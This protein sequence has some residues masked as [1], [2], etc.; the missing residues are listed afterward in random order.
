MQNIVL[1]RSRNRRKPT[2]EK[3]NAS[4]ARMTNKDVT[5]TNTYPFRRPNGKGLPVRTTR[6]VDG[7]HRRE[8]SAG[9]AF[10]RFRFDR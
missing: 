5:S 6:F 8:F 10:D 7:I 4:C 9:A 2:Q 3:H 1:D